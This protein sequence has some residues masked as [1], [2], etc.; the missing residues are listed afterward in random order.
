MADTSF[1]SEGLPHLDAT[2]GTLGGDPLPLGD[3]VSSGQ[4]YPLPDLPITWEAGLTSEV[5]FSP[6]EENLEVT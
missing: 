3:E 2:L 5:P 1:G 4:I 6:L